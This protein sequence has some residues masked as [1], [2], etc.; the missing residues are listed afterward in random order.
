M[1]RVEAL[2]RLT[3]YYKIATRTGA[4]THDYHYIE[5]ADD[6][7]LTLTSVIAGSDPV[8]GLN[9]LA[10]EWRHTANLQDRVYAARTRAW[11]DSLQNGT[12][13]A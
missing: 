1:D 12:V 4:D 10:G 9:E 13:A 2:Q 5:L 7:H 3:T 11:A 8:E 6:I